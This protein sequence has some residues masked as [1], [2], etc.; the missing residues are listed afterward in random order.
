VAINPA[1]PRPPYRQVADRLRAAIK[2]GELQPGAMLPSVRALAAE[3]GVSNTTASRALETLKSE[4]LVDTQLGRGN[5][6]RAKRPVLHVASYLTI[7][8]HGARR[9]WHREIE[10]QGFTADQAILE[11]ETVPAPV[12]IA[13]LLKLAP[14]V[15]V[16]V[17]RRL[18]SVDA[19]PVQL[20][21]SYYPASL[22]EGTELAAPGKIRGY[23][24]G[25]LERLGIHID[26]F[27]DDLYVRMPTPGEA[28]ALHLGKGI[29]VV[30]L[31]RTTYAADGLAVEVADQILA[32]DRY[33]LSYDIPAHKRSHGS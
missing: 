9:L 21:D 14:G 1:D 8:D 11:V 16:V 25:A 18:L 7:D 10:D 12:E 27:H 4:G 32:G 33:V 31:L 6:V 22:A 13:E 26:C 29:P 3:Y 2:G 30:R 19:V 28:R 17:R 23:T 24:F 20:S 15:P 5:V